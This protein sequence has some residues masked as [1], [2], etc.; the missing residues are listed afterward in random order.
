MK[1]LVGIVYDLRSDYLSE[2]YSQEDVAEFDSDATIEFLQAAI[3]R[4]G[5]RTERIGHGKALNL[6]LVAGH[7][8]DMVFNVAEGFGGRNRESYVPTLLEMYNIAYTFSDPLTCALT[9]D[10]AMAKQWVAQQHLAT[11]PFAV[12]ETLDDV[13]AVHLDY[14]LFAKPLTEGSG[15]GIDQNSKIEN[16]TKLKTVCTEL[17]SR[18]SQPVLVEEFLPG[19]EFTV[20]ILGTDKDA[21][22]LGTME[23]ELVFKNEPA[24][25]SYLNKEECESRIHYHPL[26]DDPT[27]KEKVEQLALH[28]YQVL[29]CRDAGRVDIRCDHNGTPC[30]IEVNPLAGLHPHHSDLPMIATQEGMDY[31]ALIGTILQNAFKRINTG[32]QQTWKIS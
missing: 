14:P 18:Y 3:E 16:A 28:C 26:R 17:L 23:I 30:F 13:E 10:K 8:W 27:L 9:L 7:R 4:C 11:P 32:S 20:G 5:Y 6:K 31:D 29:Q 2:G 24:I 22:V 15:K 1:P 21:R 19:R 12:V 25:Y